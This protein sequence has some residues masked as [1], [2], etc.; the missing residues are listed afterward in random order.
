MP[1][2]PAVVRCGQRRYPR[3]RHTRSNP[4]NVRSSPQRIRAATDSSSPRPDDEHV[5]AQPD[6][7]AGMLGRQFLQV[8]AMV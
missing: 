3:A 2:V 4:R 7:I 5:R 1:A 8:E 6:V